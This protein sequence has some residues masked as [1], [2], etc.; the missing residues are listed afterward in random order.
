MTAPSPQSSIDKT[1]LAQV[2]PLTSEMASSADLSVIALCRDGKWIMVG[3]KWV[4]SAPPEQDA[5]WLSKRRKERD[6]MLSFAKSASKRSVRYFAGAASD[7]DPA[8]AANWA[9][10]GRE[11]R[12]KAKQYMRWAREKDF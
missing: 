12:V 8:R 1:I 10:L 2:P 5:V 4:K 3:D 7:T 11:Q 9:R 6:A